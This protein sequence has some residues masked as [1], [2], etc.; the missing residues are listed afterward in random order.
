MQDSDLILKFTSVNFEFLLRAISFL[1]EFWLHFDY[2]TELFK[3]FKEFK[4]LCN[5]LT[6]L[7]LAKCILNAPI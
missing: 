1:L 4:Y 7:L 5:V 2:Q 3:S 6:F